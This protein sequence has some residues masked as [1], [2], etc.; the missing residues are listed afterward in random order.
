MKTAVEAGGTIGATHRRPG[1]KF[2]L[3]EMQIEENAGLG[4]GVSVLLLASLSGGVSRVRRN[5][6]RPLPV[7]QTGVRWSPLISLGGLVQQSRSRHRPISRR[8]T[9]CSS[10]FLSRAGQLAGGEKMLVARVG[11]AVFIFAAGLFIISPARP[12]F[13][14]DDVEI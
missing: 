6:W 12:C 11:V 4:F 1:C 5:S 14:S 2:H 7:W 13:Q 8:I 3:N 10:W 9:R